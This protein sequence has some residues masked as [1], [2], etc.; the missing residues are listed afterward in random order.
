MQIKKLENIQNFIDAVRSRK[1]PIAPVEVGCSTN[2]LCCIANI[3]TELQRPVRWDPATLSFG[4]D[5]EAANHRL[6][7]Y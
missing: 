1:N 2:T 5:A 6:Y 7:H 4:D 3:A